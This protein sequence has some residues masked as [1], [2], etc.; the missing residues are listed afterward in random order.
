VGINKNLKIRLYWIRVGPKSNDKYT[1]SPV[2]EQGIC[3]E[4]RVKM[5]TEAGVIH[6]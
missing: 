5:E 4:G 6:L 3:K 2:K 1:M